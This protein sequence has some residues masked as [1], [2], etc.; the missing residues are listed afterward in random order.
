MNRI[1]VFVFMA[2][3]AHELFIM[4]RSSVVRCWR[5][6]LSVSTF[7]S[8]LSPVAAPPFFS[9]SMGGASYLFV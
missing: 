7:L 2:A 4:Q 9:S 8:C 1:A 5:E 6:L 3:V